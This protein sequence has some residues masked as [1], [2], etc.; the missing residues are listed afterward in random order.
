MGFLRSIF[1]GPPS[2]PNEAETKSEPAAKNGAE[3]MR[4]MRLKWLNSSGS[5]Q[6]GAVSAVLMDWP[7]GGHIATV[8]ASAAGD[9]SIYTTSTFGIIGWIG[10]ETVRNA[11]R[12][13]IKAAEQFIPL[14]VP[15]T[16]FTYAK[17]GQI[18]FYF[19][20]PLG[21][22]GIVFRAADV[23]KEGSPARYLFA[24]GQMVVAELRL[25]GE[26]KP[27]SK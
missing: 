8:C 21:I 26:K 13:F 15:T 20:T 10:H 7:V 24:H 1:G 3:V 2:S 14:T 17:P 9:G 5:G 22:R 18:I 27:D 16:D 4:E 25:T 19:V 11:S 23:E 6:G 12:E